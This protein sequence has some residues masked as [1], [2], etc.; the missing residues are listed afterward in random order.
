[1]AAAPA[2]LVLVPVAPAT[3][4]PVLWAG[5]GTPEVNGVSLALDAPENPTTPLEPDGM[6]VVLDGLRTLSGCQHL[7][8]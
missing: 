5:D 4:P 6:A 2:L 7:C 8:G 3:P 1:M